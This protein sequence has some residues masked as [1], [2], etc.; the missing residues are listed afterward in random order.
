[1]SSCMCLGNALSAAALVLGVLGYALFQGRPLGL[2]VGLWAFAFTVA[3]AL[4]LRVAQAPLHQGRRF[5]IA[6]LLLFAALFAWHD[7]PL[8]VAANLLA[9]A[10]AV[11]L[12]A[13]RN[14]RT[15]T[16]TDY[17]E[18]FVGSAT[19]AAVGPAPLLMSDLRW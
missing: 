5:M 16:L 6:P 9:L 15:A 8:L 1:M 2:N 3:L 4:L 13:L 10:A 7:S 11:S 18:S 17:G 19:S 12:G 14:I